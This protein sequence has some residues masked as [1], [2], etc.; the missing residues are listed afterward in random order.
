MALSAVLGP[1]VN[2][3]LLKRQLESINII[4]QLCAG[5]VRILSRIDDDCFVKV[6]AY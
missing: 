4:P 5:W 1:R 2:S 6:H 3:L